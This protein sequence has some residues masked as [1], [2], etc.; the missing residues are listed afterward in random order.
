MQVAPFILWYF[1]QALTEPRQQT[2]VGV[3]QPTSAT[4]QK[5]RTP[6]HVLRF[7]RGQIGDRA[8][9]HPLSMTDTKKQIEPFT[10]RSLYRRGYQEEFRLAH[11]DMFYLQNLDNPRV[12]RG[13]FYKKDNLTGV[14]NLFLLLDSWLWELF[15]VHFRCPLYWAFLEIML[16]RCVHFVQRKK[17]S[18]LCRDIRWLWIE[19]KPIYA[20]KANRGLLRS[21]G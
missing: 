1:S 16:S 9:Q 13:S 5:A 6:V 11:M 4:L 12:I 21:G 19:M 10:R 7:D 14:F 8:D 17:I 18:I 2:P 15:R 20:S 3:P